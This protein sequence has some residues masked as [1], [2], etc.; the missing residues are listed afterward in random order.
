MIGA[1]LQSGSRPGPTSPARAS[2]VAG[3]IAFVR[4]RLNSSDPLDRLTPFGWRGGLLFILAFSLL[5]FLVCGYFVI[6]WRNA[7]MDFMVVYSA[8]AQISGAGRAF[9]DHP[10]YLTILSVEAWFRLLHSLGLLD[11]WTLSAIP[12]ASDVPA[13]DAAMT[14]AIRAARIVALL[15]AG[16]FMLGF[17]WLARRIV[18][19]ARIALCAVFAFALSGGVQSHLR[20]LRSEMIAAGC[21]ILALMLLIVVARRASLWRPLALVVAAALCVLGLENKVHAILLIA[22]LP[23]LVLP[24]GMET[25]SSVAFW[26]SSVGAWMA[27]MA[28]VVLAAAMFVVAWPI[29]AQGL[30]ATAAQ[31]AG[32]KPLLLGRFGVYQAA[33]LAWIAL[34]MTA[35]AVLFRVSPAESLASIAA[36]TGGASVALL[37][38]TIR[39]NAVDAVIVLNP[40]EKMMMYGGMSDASS[41]GGSIEILLSGL[42]GTLKRYTFVLFSSP[43]PAVFPTWLII[44]G[45]VLAF[46]R[47]EMKTALQATLLMLA[48][49]A[50]D[51]IGVR[52][53]LKVE[54]FVFTDPLIILAG[55]ILLDRLSDIRFGRWTFGIGAALIATHVGIS[56][57]EPARMLIKRSG[58]EAICEW[59]ES[60]MPKLALPWCARR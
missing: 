47:G 60:Y 24:F 25:S 28:A 37:A 49:I 38:L 27:A 11:A 9:F 51:A 6:Y 43:R 23:A 15:T 14:D 36:V 18:G 26:R 56:Q 58:P 54:Y 40:L 50:I 53:G 7:D 10:A 21:C 22:A 32:L 12:P 35:F 8:L 48:A 13:F 19:D 59:N 4:A 57:A 17:A 20:I 31:A 16:V 2:S 41:L 44:P 30:D 55:M 46:R 33:L 34:C 42:V 1:P 45:I 29:I 52:R 5:S 3:A 39:F